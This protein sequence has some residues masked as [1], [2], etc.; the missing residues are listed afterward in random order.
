MKELTSRAVAVVIVALVLAIAWSAMGQSPAP[1]RML[2]CESKDDACAESNPQYPT[3]WSF[4]GTAG[5]I[6]SP[7]DNTGAQLTILSMD[8]DRIVIFRVD[9]SGVVPGRRATYTGRI[10]G[11]R[12]TGT[13]R[14]LWAGHPDVPASGTWSAVLQDQPAAMSTPPTAG[15][16]SVQGL[17]QRLLEC[18]ANGPCNAAWIIDG[19]TGTATWFMKNPVRAQLAVIRSAPD[20]ILIRRTDLTDGNSAVYSGSRHGDS[21]SGAVVWSSP[22]HPGTASGHWSASVPETACDAGA[23]LSSADALRIGQN[24]LMF[25][26]KR[27]AFDCYIVAA[28][29]GD[30]TAQTAVGLIYYQ[31]H[32]TEVPQDY[33]QALLWLRKA[34]DQ[35]VYAAQKTVADMYMLGQGT[36]RNPELSKFYADKAAEQKADM[37]R[38][39]D[40]QERAEARKEEREDRAADRQ[41][42][43]L[44]GFVM[45][46]V[47]GALL[48]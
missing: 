22:G 45:G 41:A 1:T 31:G 25:N 23:A 43:A 37:Q 38:E 26:L 18:E 14:W 46:S 10:E 9:R 4:D 24:A 28:K 17:P 39:Q 32:D 5:T 3:M 21:Y 19:S 29:A 6:I 13:V 30:P 40:R 11:N 47:F 8:R 35:G 36:A 48:F 15:I 7:Q 42:N 2:V 16:A 20:D 27:A 44:T 12:I 34:A 33:I